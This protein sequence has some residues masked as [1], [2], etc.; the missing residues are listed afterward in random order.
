MPIVLTPQVVY[1]KLVATEAAG[2]FPG[3]DN[4]QR[5][6]KYRGDNGSRCAVG[7]CL[8]KAEAEIADRIGDIKTLTY[9]GQRDP[10]A[11]PILKRLQSGGVTLETWLRIQQAHD[12]RAHAGWKGLDFLRAARIILGIKQ[13]PE[14]GQGV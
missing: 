14:V 2:Q 7:C 9:Y 4:N 1:D 6:C 8:T 3:Y 11:K 13:D 10:K 5:R 12:D